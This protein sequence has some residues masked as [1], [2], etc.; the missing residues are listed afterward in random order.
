MFSKI[1]RSLYLG[2]RCQARSPRATPAT[3][4]CGNSTSQV[5]LLK[6]TSAKNNAEAQEHPI[7][8]ME[9]AVCSTKPPPGSGA[10]EKGMSTARGAHGQF[11]NEGRNQAGLA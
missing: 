6:P 2:G 5:A 4:T 10:D 11:H 1:D 9:R 3:P 7:L 8:G